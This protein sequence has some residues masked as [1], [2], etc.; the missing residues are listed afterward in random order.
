MPKT[1]YASAYALYQL[2][3]DGRGL[4]E[5]CR[6]ERLNYITF[7]KWLRIQNLKVTSA[8]S[9]PSNP[10]LAPM[11]ITGSPL[12]EKK[13]DEP[14]NHSS[15]ALYISSICITFSEGMRIQK[16]NTCIEWVQELFKKLRS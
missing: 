3:S 14:I 5:Y 10:K 2:Y 1:D 16:Y 9:T 7:S 15:D 13:N 11:E 12:E 4:K 6:E 8:P